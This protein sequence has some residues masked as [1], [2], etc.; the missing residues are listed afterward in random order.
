MLPVLRPSLGAAAS[1]V[2][3]QRAGLAAVV[4]TRAL[5]VTS[6]AFRTRARL[7]TASPS[8]TATSQTS[9]SFLHDHPYP[10]SQQVR[11]YRRHV[12]PKPTP[13]PTSWR[14][15]TT[16]R[17]PPPPWGVQGQQ[18]QQQRRFASND[19]WNR[20]FNERVDP[21][22][23]HRRYADPL[24][25][26][27]DFK[28]AARHQNTKYLAIF[29]VA[30]TI[31]FYF[32]NL[33]TVPVSGRTRFNIYSRKRVVEAGE[34][35]YRRLLYDL[36]Q[37]GVG[38]LPDW[39]YRTQRV[40]RVMAKLIPFSGMRD[41]KWEI[42]V[43]DDPHT[44]NA[45]VLPGGKVFVF[46]GILH[47]ARTD[48]QLATVLGHEIAHNVA[49]HVG[50]RMSQ[51]IGV[52]ILL[53]SLVVLTGIFGVGALIAQFGG[54]WALNTA[55]SNPM[56]RKQESEADYI[57]LMMMAEACYDPREAVTFWER[58]DRKTQE[59]VPEWMS[60]HPSHSN[61]IEKIQ[62]WLPEALEKRE[63]SDCRTTASF[64]DLFRQALLNGIIEIRQY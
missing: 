9:R 17:R 61:R 8:T 6:A 34:L 21:Y 29:C 28:K 19:W 32:I 10:S 64:A 35:S 12:T 5:A 38:V 48:S 31:I 43:I 2:I 63:R 23:V 49:D 62:D 25:T 50:E 18:H 16:A 57:G 33:E 36:E 3:G 27:Q 46:S 44:A 22:G 14:P 24:F 51:N 52:N 26:D 47:L 37:Q 53:Y 55:I 11:A 58:M 56:S 13:T 4:G 39:D 41:E 1:T 30:G 54:A 42:F 20:S 60:T 7:N 15:T 59:K 45:F 40:K